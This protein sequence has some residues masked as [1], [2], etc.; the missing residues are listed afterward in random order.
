MNK[1][2]ISALAATLCIGGVAGAQSLAEKEASALAKFR[3]NTNDVGALKA[4]AQI[5]EARGNWSSASATWGLV[6]KK[7]DNRQ[8]NA[9]NDAGPIP[10]GVLSNWWQER[11]ARRRRDRSSSALDRR[12]AERA[13]QKLIK[14]PNIHAKRVD[15]DGDGLDE[16]AYGVTSRPD[17]DGY[18]SFHIVKWN[19]GRY[20]TVWTSKGEMTP[21]VF[22]VAKGPWPAIY[23]DYVDRKGI[24]TQLKG[25]RS[26]GRSIVQTED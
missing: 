4:L 26:N 3:A 12:R 9:R 21:V 19:N 16:I 23:L 14:D 6:R 2:I 13:Y 7:F 17:A 5:R 1:I 20:A 11:L 8:S 25:L 15:M 24:G 22:S 10:Y 18:M